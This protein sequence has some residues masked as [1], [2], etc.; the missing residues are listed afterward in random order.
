VPDKVEIIAEQLVGSANCQ[1]K[2]VHDHDGTQ[3]GMRSTARQ[4]GDDIFDDDFAPFGNRRSRSFDGSSWR[5]SARRCRSA[6][7]IDAAVQIRI[8]R[9]PP[10]R[11]PTPSHRGAT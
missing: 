3:R 6:P 9:C 2:G 10:L 8:Q 1:Q 11:G 5:N 7:I 4:V